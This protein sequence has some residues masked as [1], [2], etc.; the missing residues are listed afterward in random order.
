MHNEA[1]DFVQLLCTSNNDGGGNNVDNNDGKKEALGVY[2]QITCFIKLFQG[3]YKKN[4]LKTINYAMKMSIVKHTPLNQYN[5][6]DH[7]HE[8]IL[9]QHCK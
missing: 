5:Y 1:Y 9:I 8:K 3:Q 4:A 2:L 6:I 7:T